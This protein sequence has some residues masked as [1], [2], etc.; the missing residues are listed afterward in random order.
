MKA[1]AVGQS[2]EDTLQ[3]Y[4]GGRESQWNSVLDERQRFSLGEHIVWWKS[5]QKSK[6]KIILNCAYDWNTE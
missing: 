5:K 4:L 2:D 6:E 1:A 3:G